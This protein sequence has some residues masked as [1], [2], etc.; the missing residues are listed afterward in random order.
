MEETFANM[1]DDMEYMKDQEN[2]AE[3][4]LNNL[5][6][7]VVYDVNLSELGDDTIESKI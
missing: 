6:N 4:E 5:I 7:K 2:R 3:V 1:D